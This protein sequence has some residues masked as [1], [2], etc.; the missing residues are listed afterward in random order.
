[1]T[2]PIQATREEKFGT[3]GLALWHAVSANFPCELQF[4]VKA[5]L[6]VLDTTCMDCTRHVPGI[7]PTFPIFT[8]HCSSRTGPYFTDL[9]MM[10]SSL[11]RCYEIAPGFDSGPRIYVEYLT[12]LYLVVE[13]EQ[14]TMTLLSSCFYLSIC[15]E[16]SP[17]FYLQNLELLTF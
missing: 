16:S 8:T 5:L 9:G 11:R 14:A 6:K 3:L 13:S 2:L 4:I 1:M 10:E 7:T 17:K 12:T 15:K